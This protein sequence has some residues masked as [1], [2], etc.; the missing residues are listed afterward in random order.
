MAA[1]QSARQV[2]KNYRNMPGF[3]RLL[4]KVQVK[5]AE[6]G[7]LHCEVPVTEEHLNIHGILHGGFTATLIDNISTF[8]LLTLEKP[9]FGVSV[10]LNI[11][12]LSSAAK[13]DTLSVK[14]EVLKCGKTLGFS[15]ISVENQHGKLVAAA[16]QTLAIKK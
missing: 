16:R 11:T 4:H 14:S 9:F 1:L 2:F 3:D 5:A 12:F 7:K 10:D 8:S 6:N 15:S 13:G